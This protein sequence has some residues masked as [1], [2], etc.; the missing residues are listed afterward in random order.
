MLWGLVGSRGGLWGGPGLGGAVP[1]GLVGRA[2]FVCRCAV[3][4]GGERLLVGR[5][6]SV[7]RCAVG[8]G[9]ESLVRVALCREDWWGEPGLCVAVLWG[10]VGRAWSGRRCASALLGAPLAERGVASLCTHQ[11]LARGATPESLQDWPDIPVFMQNEHFQY[12][13]LRPLP[14]PGGGT[15]S[16][17][18]WR[19]SCIHI[20]NTQVLESSYDA[21]KGHEFNRLGALVYCSPRFETAVGYARATN[22]FNND[23]YHR[24]VLELEVDKR[25]LKHSKKAGGL[26]W[27]LQPSAV[28]VIGCWFILNCGN[29]VGEDFLREWKPEEEIL[30]EGVVAAR[31]GCATSFFYTLRLLSR[32][33]A[34][35]YH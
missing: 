32:A 8:V 12:Y 20:C 18:D 4:S 34:L 22:L 31:L 16:A 3:G 33:V 5:A 25:R 29:V 24:V 14:G 6:W 10:L 26:Q 35:N 9:G 7:C 17:G 23:C 21:A 1:W 13:A 15:D 2:W 11:G 28:R 19:P 30:P 27:T